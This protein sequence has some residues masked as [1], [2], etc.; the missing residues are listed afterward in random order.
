MSDEIMVLLVVFLAVFTQS[1]SGFGSAMVAMALLP[2]VLG[3]KV[4][5]PLVALVMLVMEAYL[6][7]HYRHALS[8][9]VIWRVVMAAALGIPIGII[10]LS[11]LDEK[12]VLTVLGV[13]ITGYSLFALI[14]VRLPQLKHPAWGY[15]FGLLGGLLGG[16]Y[17]TSGPPVIL[18]GD[19]RG[20]EPEA[21]KSNLQGY[22]LVV[23]IIVALGHAWDGNFT[24]DV[25]RYFLISIPALVVGILGGTSLDKFTN[26]ETFRKAV[27][28]L[29]VIMG[30]R[31]IIS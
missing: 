18:Y 12:V 10:F 9:K 13:V 28:A 29:L 24:L 4:A 16:A 26:K 30:V 7:Y 14:N 15:L 3:I 22:F 21:F 23:S 19:C 20:W 27:L 31:L 5:T 1:F 17:N 2:S 6:I 8:I 25:W 11:R